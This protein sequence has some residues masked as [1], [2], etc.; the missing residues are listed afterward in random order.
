[1]LLSH[2][3]GRARRADHRRLDM[4]LST[5]ACDQGAPT[6]SKGAARMNSLTAGCTY[7][8]VAFNVDNVRLCPRLILGERRKRVRH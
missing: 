1:M 6:K 3:R 2:Q 5:I 7:T 8:A 4:L